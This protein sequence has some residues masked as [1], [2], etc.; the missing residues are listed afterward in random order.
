MFQSVRRHQSVK[1]LLAWLEQRARGGQ[2]TR[3]RASGEEVTRAEGAA[4]T[5]LRSGTMS[6]SHSWVDFRDGGRGGRSELHFGEKL[7]TSPST[8][9]R[10]KHGVEGAH[11]QDDPRKLQ[12]QGQK[13]E[14]GIWGQ[15]SEG[16]VV[17]LVISVGS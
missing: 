9:A 12:G 10:D 3:D 15:D 17:E 13:N 11:L 7:V 1:L 6:R 14:L 8:R 4:W 2:E 5:R 16:C